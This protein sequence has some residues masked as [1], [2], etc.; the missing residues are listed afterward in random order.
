MACGSPTGVRISVSV[1]R[2]V[3][4]SGSSSIRSGA[5]HRRVFPSDAGSS[6][7]PW[8]PRFRSIR[9]AFL[10]ACG[11]SCPYVFHVRQAVVR[12]AYSECT[13]VRRVRVPGDVPGVDQIG[14]LATEGGL[15]DAHFRGQFVL[16]A[17]TLP[18][19]TRR[20]P[21]RARGGGRRLPTPGHRE[22][23][24]RRGIPRRSELRSC[25]AKRTTRK[26]RLAWTWQQPLRTTYF[27][28][29]TIYIVTPSK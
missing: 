26:T 4:Q 27:L 2:F 24:D 10:H 3:F 21:V 16:P 25:R 1:I 28:H 11:T 17:F 13:P 8:L 22:A 20:T 9:S 6:R 14:D 19:R 23:P 12:H 7:G 15:T 5:R 18:A 29:A